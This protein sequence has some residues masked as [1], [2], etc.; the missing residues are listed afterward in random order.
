MCVGPRS[1]AWSTGVRDAPG[2]CR[3]V[4]RQELGAQPDP[5]GGLRG[6]PAGGPAHSIRCDLLGPIHQFT[7]DLLAALVGRLA[8]FID[9]LEVAGQRQAAT[10]AMVQPINAVGLPALPAR[11]GLRRLGKVAG[12]VAEQQF[13]QAV[14]FE[15]GAGR[16]ARACASS[17]RGAA[18]RDGRWGRRS[19]RTGPRRRRAMNPGAGGGPPPSGR[20]AGGRGLARRRHRARAAATSGPQRSA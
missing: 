8:E 13:V 9:A 12:P 6:G 4:H 3:D 1:P 19:R 7:Q 15:G 2:R 5:G 10:G 20:P 14:V 17:W 16:V 11:P 18:A